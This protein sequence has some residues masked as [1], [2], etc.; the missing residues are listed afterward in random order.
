MAIIA[1]ASAKGGTGK[2]THACQVAQVR[3]AMNRKVLI[4][5]MDK[6]GSLRVW[7]QQRG[8]HAPNAVKLHFM[9]QLGKGAGKCVMDFAPDYDDI[10]L[11]TR[12]SEALNREMRE[13]MLIADK[14]IMPIKPSLFD[15]ATAIDVADAVEEAR[16]INPKLQAF[17]LLNECSPHYRGDSAAQDVRSELSEMPTFTMMNTQII[18]RRIYMRVAEKGQSVVEFARGLRHADARREIVELAH[19]VWQ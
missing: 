15:S 5:D 3:A 13:A 8:K 1:F 10:V 11:D 4:V 2:T 18:H 17:I 9:T 16:I 7:Y 19:E 6:Q 14:I 12:G